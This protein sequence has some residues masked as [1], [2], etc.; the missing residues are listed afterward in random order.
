MLYGQYIG[1]I[2]AYSLLPTS[3][4]SVLQMLRAWP[5][6]AKARSERHSFKPSGKGAPA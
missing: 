4:I 2:F 1:A 3:E 5:I 6:H